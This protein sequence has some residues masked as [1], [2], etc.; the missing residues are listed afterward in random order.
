MRAVIDACGRWSKVA[1]IEA[2]VITASGCGVTVK[3][4]G[5][6]LAQ[7]AE[8]RE[9]AGAHF[10]LARDLCEVI[11]LEAIPQRTG[12]RA[13]PFNL[14]AR[15]SNGQQIRG[16]VEA[17]LVRAGYELTSVRDAHP[18]LWFRGNVFI[19]AAARWPASCARASWPALHKACAVHRHRPTSLPFSPAGRHRRLRSVTGSSFSMTRWSVK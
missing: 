15:C 8:Y 3:E 2:I 10:R 6:L 11:P 9:K 14:P 5:H 4:Y 18:M 13:S 16:R 7:D 1:E 19:A 12:G 17:L